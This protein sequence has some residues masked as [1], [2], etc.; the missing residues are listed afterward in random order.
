MTILFNKAKQLVV[1][2]CSASLLSACMTVNADMSYEAY[3]AKLQSGEIPSDGDLPTLKSEHKSSPVERRVGEAQG[4]SDKSSLNNKGGNGPL[5]DQPLI[6]DTEQLADDDGIGSMNFQWQVQEPT[7]RWVIADGGSS[8][9]FT[10]RQKDV[11]KPLRAKID[12]LD[13]QGTLETIITPATDP[14]RNVN[15]LP[16]GRP[17]IAG[18]PQEDETLQIDSS[19]VNDEDGLGTINYQWER[20]IDGLE[21]TPYPGNAGDPSLL[22]L[23]QAEVGYAYRGVISYVDGFG[24][25]ESM[26]TTSSNIVRNLDDPTVG[27]L[28]MSGSYQK[29]SV[30][31]VDTSKISDEDGIASINVSWQISNDGRNWRAASDV[32]NRALKLS[33]SEV[34]MVVR[35]SAIVVDNYGSQAI[36]YGP[37]STPIAN[38]NAKPRGMVRI[39]AA[40]K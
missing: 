18:M 17:S 36:I 26:I 39:M 31:K 22:R 28:E 19:S 34:G 20:S 33:S 21:W 16:V 32:K 40:E 27:G 7:G 10:P 5:E 25:K 1:A 2:F 12:Y 8:H 30:L 6:L 11:G 37:V 24:T 13:G 35:A 14:V 23:S 3:E 9:A 29:G 38:V 15:D 4:S